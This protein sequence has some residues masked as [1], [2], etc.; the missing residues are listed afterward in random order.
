MKNLKICA[1]PFIFLITSSCVSRPGRPDAPMCGS[2][3]DCI[4]SRGETQEDP[5]LLLC[6]TPFGY[7]N[8]EDYI[9]RLELRVRELERRCRK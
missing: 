3:G 7:S 1:I 5:R 6:T 2:S 9:D 8:Y 4:D